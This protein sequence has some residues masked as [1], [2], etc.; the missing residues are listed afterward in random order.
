M[1]KIFLSMLLF[2][3]SCQNQKKKNNIYPAQEITNSENN[4]NSSDWVTLFDGETFNGWH[5]YNSSG[6]INSWSIIDSS[7]VL[8]PDEENLGNGTGK[9]LVTD[10]SYTNFELSLEWKISEG[11][12]S[13]I[14]WGVVEDEKFPTPYITGPEIQVLD[15]EKHKDAF[16]KPKFHQAGSLYDIVEPSSDV[17]NPAGEWN[18]VLLK[19]NH[20]TNKGEVELNGTLIASFPLSGSEWDKLI[21]N[22]KF[23]DINDINYDPLF[24]PNFG[25]FKTG[26]IGLQDHGNV[27]SYKNIKIREIE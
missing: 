10:N 15:N 22:T 3:F 18:H 16:I 9:D 23:R 1:K 13:G 17:C 19:I 8:T 7:M 6:E 12:N 27:V 26:K 2:I 14:F 20:S 4:K 11:G 21:E 5:I 24:N 25:N